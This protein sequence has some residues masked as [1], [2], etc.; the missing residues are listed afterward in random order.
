MHPPTEGFIQGHHPPT[1]G[2]KAHPEV[3]R[4]DSVA[5]NP[6]N[7][8]VKPLQQ[9]PSHCRLSQAMNVAIQP[10][11]EQDMVIGKKGCYE[12]C[13]QKQVDAGVLQHWSDVTAC[14]VPR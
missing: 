14:S 5:F 11:L 7:E 4:N 2:L 3:P 8:R 1:E 10:P 12:L 13:Q 9:Q 6:G